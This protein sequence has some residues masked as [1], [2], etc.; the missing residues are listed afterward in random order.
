MAMS[1][2][3]LLPKNDTSTVCHHDKQISC[4]NCRL[5]NLCLPL[6][7]ELDELNQIDDVILRDKPLHKGQYLYENGRPFTSIFAVRSGSV[8]STY[9]SEEGEEQITGFYLPGEILG[10]DGLSNN[11]YV[12]SAVALETS[13]ICEIPFDK[14]EVLSQAIPSLQRHFFQLMSREIT[15]D[16]QLITL[17]T[18]GS[19][20]Q[21]IAALLLSLSSR[22][23]RRQLSNTEFLLPMSRTD[24]GNYLGLTIETVSRTFSR[25]QKSNIIS[26]DRRLVNILKFDQLKS[27]AAG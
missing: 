22:N 24:L 12:N 10:M 21:R 15:N 3:K 1:V 13:S 17:L 18:K 26:T 2:S 20:E 8:K 9:L 19:S 7:L 6:S 16:Q 4:S 25:L 14:L 27:I 23:K 11:T 5:S